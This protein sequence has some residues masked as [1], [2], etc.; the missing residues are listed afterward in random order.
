MRA[1]PPVSWIASQMREIFA[2]VVA[3]MRTGRSV[4]RLGEPVDQTGRRAFGA[5]GSRRA[6][7]TQRTISCSLRTLLF[8]FKFTVDKTDLDARSDDE[9]A[10]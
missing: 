7:L 5:S 1:R 2:S 10:P 3:R 6:R 8:R 4:L 9:R